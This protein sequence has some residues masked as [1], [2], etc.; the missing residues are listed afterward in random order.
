MKKIKLKVTFY[1]RIHAPSAT[2]DAMTNRISLVGTVCAT[3]LGFLMQHMSLEKTASHG[4]RDRRG[5]GRNSHDR[6]QYGSLKWR[7]FCG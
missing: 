5:R 1:L 6:R 3:S 2:L 4:S 7:K